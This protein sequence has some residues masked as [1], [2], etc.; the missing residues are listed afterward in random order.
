[1]HAL[2]SVIVAPA[3]RRDVHVKDLTKNS[4]TIEILSNAGPVAVG[5]LSHIAYQLVSIYFVSKLGEGI[6]AG[7]NAAGNVVFILGALLQ[8]LS[9][10]TSVLVAHATG[11]K[12]LAD[13]NLI[14]N[15]AISLSGL[16]ALLLV[17]LMCLLS[18]PYMEV[19]TTDRTAVDAGVS[20]MLAVA[21]GYALILP[22]S[23][24]SA[25]LRGSGRSGGEGSRARQHHGAEM[26]CVARHR[27]SPLFHFAWCFAQRLACARGH[28]SISGWLASGRP[29]RDR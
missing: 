29:F 7:V 1:M 4:I 12:D 24:L 5:L 9:I 18:R 27:L 22:M 19:V 23:V 10:G 16:L 15:Q 11:R 13:A 26:D 14:F 28:S 3:L 21:P 6:T 17:P 20:F 25:A 2:L 8:V